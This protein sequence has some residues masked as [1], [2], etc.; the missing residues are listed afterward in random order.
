M[1]HYIIVLKCFNNAALNMFNFF[2]F[3]AFGKDQISEGLTKLWESK[4]VV[5]IYQNKWLNDL[6]EF[7]TF[8]FPICKYI[9]LWVIIKRCIVSYFY[10]LLFIPSDNI[11]TNTAQKMKF[12]IKNFFNKCDKIHSLELPTEDKYFHSEVTIKLPEGIW[13]CFIKL[14]KLQNLGRKMK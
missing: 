11:I 1:P 6:V 12:S 9:F 3:S 10:H 5:E 14:P 13:A 8:Y 2:L 4:K 7:C